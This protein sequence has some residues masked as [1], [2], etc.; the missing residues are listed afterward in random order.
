MIKK[1]QGEQFKEIKFKKGLLKLRYAISNF[2]RMVSFTNK[3]DDGRLLKGS[4]VEGYPTFSCRPGGDYKT[5]FYHR[6]VAENFVGGHSKSKAWVIHVD[7]NKKHNHYKNL[8]WVTQDDMV[9]H[10]QSSPAVK[11][12]RKERS[13]IKPTV[14][15]KLN[16]AQVKSL[17]KLIGAKNRSKTLKQIAKQFK[18]SEMQL[19]RIKSGENWSHIKA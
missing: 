13:K 15:L 19:Y 14:G 1:L 17:K 3:V 5:L 16:A 18:I 6:L 12:A 11:R 10:H 8:K 7:H 9:N 2:G 4:S